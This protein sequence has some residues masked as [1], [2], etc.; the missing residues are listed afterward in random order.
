MDDN[1]IM[2]EEMEDAHIVTLIDEEGNE[3]ELEHID[4][5]ELDGETYVAL[6]P[7]FDSAEEYVD[8]DAS[9]EIMKIVK[10]ENGEETLMVLDSEEEFNKV[11]AVFTERLAEE[12]EII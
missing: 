11:I 2:N 6:V 5:V 3:F 1:K 8:A 9:L 7:V 4:T 12:F 10:L